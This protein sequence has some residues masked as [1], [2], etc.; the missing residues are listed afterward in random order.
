MKLGMYKKD[1]TLKS[2]PKKILVVDDDELL[3]EAVP[4]M[5]CS[6]GYDVISANNGDSGL[7]LFLK[8]KC[9]IVLTDLEMPGLDGISLAL[10]IKE[11]SPDTPVIL[12]TGHDRESIM[13]Q[14]RDSAVDMTLFKPFDLFALGQLLPEA[15]PQREKKPISSYTYE[16]G[17]MKDLIKL[18]A[19]ALVDQPEQVSVEEVGGNH[20]SVLELRVA[21]ADMGKV[22][23]KRGRNAT[24][25]R[26]II[27]A[28]S[29][30]EKKRVMLEIL[31]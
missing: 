5:L 4:Q 31:E 17:N 27:G 3:L 10:H 29:G 21:K 30:K 8:R 19:E 20:S 22:I 12:M 28:V 11:K 18:I 13:G 9:D 6:L 26:T 23:G 14:M 7:N 2:G 25:M 16:G 1:P 24:A 15:W